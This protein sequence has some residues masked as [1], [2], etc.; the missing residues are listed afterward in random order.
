MVFFWCLIFM[1][2]VSVLPGKPWPKH[3]CHEFLC[4]YT[5]MSLHPGSSQRMVQTHLH[6]GGV[7]WMPHRWVS[8]H[9]SCQ[10]TRRYKTRGGIRIAKLWIKTVFHHILKHRRERER[11]RELEKT[12]RIRVLST[13]LVVFENVAKTAKHLLLL[14]FVSFSLY[15]TVCIRF[16]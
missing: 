11:E 13:N 16:R 9:N 4:S 2:S 6:E 1:L 14:F 12:K 8:I 3:S 15:Q 10:L 5:A 7:L